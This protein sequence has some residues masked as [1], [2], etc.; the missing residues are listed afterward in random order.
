MANNGSNASSPSHASSSGSTDYNTEY[1]AEVLE[2]ITHDRHY[3]IATANLANYLATL[4]DDPAPDPVEEQLA[5]EAWAEGAALET[6]FAAEGYFS[7]PSSPARPV[8]T[9]R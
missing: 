7:P 6:E 5:A 9:T 2:K 1:L 8:P 4:S 3:D